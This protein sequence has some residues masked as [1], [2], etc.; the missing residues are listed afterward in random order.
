MPP[1][2]TANLWSAYQ[3]LQKDKV[4]Q[5]KDPARL[6]TNI[7]QLVRFAIGQDSELQDFSRSANSKFELWKGRQIKRGIQ[8]SDEQNQW[9]EEIKNYI[10]ANAY[11]E[12]SD[13]HEAMQ[14]EGGIIKAKQVFGENLA[15]ILDDL[16]L[17]LVG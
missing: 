17:T 1:L 2:E 11:M 8:F 13:I 15:D 16:S 6:L 9:L 3:L 5:I 12:L 10:V 14:H 7:V 4:Q